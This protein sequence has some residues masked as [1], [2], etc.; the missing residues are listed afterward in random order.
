MH[1][2]RSPKPTVVDYHCL[3]LVSRTIRRR[4]VRVKYAFGMTYINGAERD[5]TAYLLVANQVRG[6][7]IGA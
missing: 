4:W 2:V 1:M 3:G 6:I 5:R 7:A